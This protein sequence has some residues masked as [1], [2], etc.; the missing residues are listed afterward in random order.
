MRAPGLA[1]MLSTPT[2]V[3][4]GIVAGGSKTGAEVEAPR[5]KDSGYKWVDS[6]TV[7]WAGGGRSMIISSA[8]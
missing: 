5:E 8:G 4:V 7:G 1:L 2:L 6:S 3:G